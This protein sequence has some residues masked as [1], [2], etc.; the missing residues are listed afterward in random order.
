MQR[1]SQYYRNLA[2]GG[3]PRNKDVQERVDARVVGKEVWSSSLYRAGESGNGWRRQENDN[4]RKKPNKLR[5]AIRR[6]KK[7]EELRCRAKS[8]FE[9]VACICVGGGDEAFQVHQDQRHSEPSEPSVQ[10]PASCVLRLAFSVLVCLSLAVPLPLIKKLPL[11]L[12]TGTSASC[13]LSLVNVPYY[14]DGASLWG[15]HARDILGPGGMVGRGQPEW[16][17]A[18][19]WPRLDEH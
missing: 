1:E 4:N 6:K 12:C 10:R 15:P 8:L 5:N 3:S 19:R 17:A 18:R 9:K 16:T 14:G 13:E 11:L 7:K 2:K